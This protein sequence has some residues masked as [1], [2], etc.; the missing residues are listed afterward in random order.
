VSALPFTLRV[1]DW[2][3]DE[4]R[5]RAVRTA[6]F[7]IE[8]SIPDELEWDAEDPVSVHALAEATDGTPLGCARL[9]PDGHVGRVAVLRTWRGRGVGAA[10]VEHLVALA[11]ARGHTSVELHAQTHALPFYARLGFVPT[12]DVFMEADLPHQTMRR[13]FD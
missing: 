6:V 4:P 7:V 8:Q 11:R 5:L 2:A 13:V 3:H 9:L 12:G 10:L 1:T